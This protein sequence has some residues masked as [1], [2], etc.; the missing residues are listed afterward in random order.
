MYCKCIGEQGSFELI[1]NSS[2]AF[3]VIVPH[4]SPL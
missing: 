3:I 4:W 1:T 2:C